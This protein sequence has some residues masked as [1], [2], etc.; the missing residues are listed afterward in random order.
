M[1]TSRAMLT[2]ATYIAVVPMVF[3]HHSPIAFDGERIVQ[4]QGTVVWF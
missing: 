2:I 1:P 3:A 4:I